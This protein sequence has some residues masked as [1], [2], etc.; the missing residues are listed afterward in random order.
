[1]NSDH[2]LTGFTMSGDIA[3]RLITL[4]EMYSSLLPS[5]ESVTA[6]ASLGKY[7]INFYL[8]KDICCV[9][10]ENQDI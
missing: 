1:M 6:N 2:L 5:V 4:K 10:S 7:L 3:T 8:A 9:V